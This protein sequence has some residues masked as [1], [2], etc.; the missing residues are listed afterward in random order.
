MS[1]QSDNPTESQQD[2]P[3][4]LVEVDH[5]AQPSSG[6]ESTNEGTQDLALSQWSPIPDQTQTQS[7][8]DA[9]LTG[10]AS[11]TSRK[12]KREPENSGRRMRQQAKLGYIKEL[13]TQLAEIPTDQSWESMAEGGHLTS[14]SRIIDS[15]MRL[16]NGLLPLHDTNKTCALVSYSLSQIRYYYDPSPSNA[17]ARETAIG[18]L[19]LATLDF[20]PLNQRLSDAQKDIDRFRDEHLARKKTPK[21]CTC[22]CTCG[23]NEK[24]SGL[25]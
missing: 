16:G 18:R 6:V 25:K 20:E 9:A 17:A 15:T 3:A 24:G 11:D 13:E 14:L 5:E 19:L 21:E 2:V 4:I 8:N 1:S 22:V 23:A 12:R 10:E 7:Q